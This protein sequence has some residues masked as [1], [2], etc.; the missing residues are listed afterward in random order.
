MSN[1]EV[2]DFDEAHKNVIGERLA[3]KVAR[4]LEDGT[5]TLEQL[6]EISSYI[7]DNIDT[8][9][10]HDQLMT[11]LTNLSQKWPV[12]SDVLTMEEGEV[13]EKKEDQKIEQVE[14]LLKENKIDEALKVAESATEQGGNINGP[15]NP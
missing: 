3:R 2:M 15:T 4:A 14:D 9:T 5:V 1:N 10:T 7:L 11:F 12:F 13:Q 8:I 6:P